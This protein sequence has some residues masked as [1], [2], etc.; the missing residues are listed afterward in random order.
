VTLA[1]HYGMPQ[2]Q[3]IADTTWLADAGSRGWA[4]L[5][6]DD[7]IRFNPPERAAVI[8]YEVRCFC[9][10]RQNLLS[11]EM[12]MWFL[13]NLRPMTDACRDPGPFVYAV[14]ETK[15]AKML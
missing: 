3:D 6:K 5:L 13:R 4:V 14:H 2:D 15:I 1:E 10:T 7:R 11:E 8:A 12:A 9:L